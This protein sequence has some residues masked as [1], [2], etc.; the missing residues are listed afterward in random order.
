MS[1]K[2][3]KPQHDSEKGNAARP[4]KQVPDVDKHI[5]ATADEEIPQDEIKSGNK[6]K[7]EAKK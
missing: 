6:Q 3:P 1:D 5:G 4:P 2:K 7:A